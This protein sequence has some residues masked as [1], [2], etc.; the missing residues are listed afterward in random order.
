MS[1]NLGG[2]GLQ[3]EYADPGEFSSLADGKPNESIVTSHEMSDNKT[4]TQLLCIDVIPDMKERKN[5]TSI[6]LELHTYQ[7]PHRYPITPLSL[8]ADPDDEL[9]VNLDVLKPIKG[10]KQILIY[11]TPSMKHVARKILDIGKTS[12]QLGEIRWSHFENEFPNLR[13]KDARKIRFHHVAFLASL[14]T[15]HV[16]FEQF[17]VMC[18]IP[19]HLAKSV[20]VFVPYFPVGTMERVTKY[21]EIATADT[22]SRMLSTIP[23]CARGPCQIVIF[24]VHALQNQFYFSDNILI[25]LETA[26]PLLHEAMRRKYQSLEDVAVAFPDEG[27]YKRFHML[28]NEEQYGIKEIIVCEKRRDGDKRIV[29]IKEGNPKD[30]QV[31]IV[32]DLV[33]TGG[34]LVNCAKACLDFGARTVSC[35][36]THGVFPMNSWKRFAPGGDNENLFDTFWITNSIPPVVKCIG[37]LKP[38]KILDLSPLYLDILKER[39]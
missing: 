12:I 11:Y 4:N 13:I 26:I 36:C 24:D 9:P 20:L 31:I 37:G 38:F 23:N 18:A 5:S 3:F 27:A 30:K 1:E 39:L 25:R 8:A 28:F 15:P 14:S 22:L 10:E 7:N 2:M 21:G 29:T 33:Q 17:A 16:L 6:N 32:D 35:Y 34:T 19:K